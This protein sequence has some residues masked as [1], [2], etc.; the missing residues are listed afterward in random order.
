MQYGLCALAHHMVRRPC[1]L[2][3]MGL[4]PMLHGPHHMVAPYVGLMSCLMCMYVRGHFHA[5]VCRVF[6]FV[7]PPLKCVCAPHAARITYG[8][9]HSTRDTYRRT[10]P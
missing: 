7:K 1:L 6:N 3:H 5:Y 9:A 10:G 4:R 2:S 8:Y